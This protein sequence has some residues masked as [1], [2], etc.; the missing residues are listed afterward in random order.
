MQQPQAVKIIPSNR[1]SVIKFQSDAIRL[2]SNVRFGPRNAGAFN[3]SRGRWGSFGTEATLDD[4]LDMKCTSIPWAFYKCK[5]SLKRVQHFRDKPNLLKPRQQSFPYQNHHLRDDA[6][7]PDSRLVAWNLLRT[8]PS[9]TSML[10]EHLQTR[11][12]FD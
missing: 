3:V 8:Q 11:I 1:Q 2:E 7:A 9:I 12:H 5:S 10:L 4:P 6:L